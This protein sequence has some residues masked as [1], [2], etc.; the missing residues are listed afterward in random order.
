MIIDRI[1][2]HPLVSITMGMA[3]VP[4]ET[5]CG[6]VADSA[7]LVAE[8]SFLGHVFQCVDSYDCVW[9]DMQTGDF[10]PVGGQ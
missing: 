7:W 2:I 10:V 4:I 9:M 1:E 3:E 5:P 6:V 8:V